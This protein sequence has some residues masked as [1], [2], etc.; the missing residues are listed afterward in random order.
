MYFLYFFLVML[1][2]L[3]INWL[4]GNIWKFFIHSLSNRRNFIPLLSIYFLTLPNTTAQQIWLF[5]GIWFLAMFFLE[6]PSG[7]FA[8]NFW[9][10][11]T[12]VLSKI[13]MILSTVSFILWDSVLYFII[14]SIF[15][16]LW[17][18]FASG[19]QQA[20]LHETLNELV[21]WKDYTKIASR[22]SGRVSL[23][24]AFLIISLPFFTAIDIKLPFEIW[25]WFDIIGFIVVLTMVSPSFSE[26]IKTKKSITNILKEVRWTNFYIIAIFVALISWVLMSWVPFRDIYL[27]SIGL[28]V[29]FVGFVMGLSRVFWFM[30]SQVAHKI[31]KIFTIKQLLLIEIFIFSGGLILFSLF[32]NPYIAWFIIALLIGYRS[33]R[34]SIISNY[35]MN[36]LPDPKYKA[37]MLSVQQQMTSIIQVVLVFSIWFVMNYS[38]QLWFLSL[39]ILLFI[40]LSIS[41]F[42][43]QKVKI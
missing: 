27:K 18:A 8:D 38:Y 19:T 7:Y 28:P 40:L 3:K 33:G 2:K 23:I 1:K 39:G 25:L 10:K 21:M 24:S 37:T 30:I 11:R 20:F 34:S 31:E 26:S 32:K 29:V 5:T 15:L 12:L 16:N 6:I 35:L 41:Y 42:F 13:L 14:W 4:E 17:F 36:I 43:V 9:H 22:T